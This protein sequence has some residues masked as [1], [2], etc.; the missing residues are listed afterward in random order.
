MKDFNGALPFFKYCRSKTRSI[1]I[2][3]IIVTGPGPTYSA[4]NKS[5]KNRLAVAC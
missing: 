4:K 5:K 1:I 2:F 3:V